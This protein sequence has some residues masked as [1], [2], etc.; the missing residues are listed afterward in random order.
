MLIQATSP[1]PMLNAAESPQHVRIHTLRKPRVSEGEVTFVVGEARME[2]EPYAVYPI[3]GESQFEAMEYFLPFYRVFGTKKPVY[4]EAAIQRNIE[5]ETFKRVNLKNPLAPTR[6]KTVV[7]GDLPEKLTGIQLALL[8]STGYHVIV[9]S[10]YRTEGATYKERTMNFTTHCPVNGGGMIRIANC[11]IDVANPTFD[12]HAPL[13]EH[14]YRDLTLLEAFN[15]THRLRTSDIEERRRK[16]I[17]EAEANMGANNL[18]GRGTPVPRL[19][20]GSDD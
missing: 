19:P 18:L 4:D 10:A 8:G 1:R 15:R 12:P 2:V 11:P 13:P 16:R 3:E 6:S 14:R 7:G 5:S 17:A 9:K 20:H